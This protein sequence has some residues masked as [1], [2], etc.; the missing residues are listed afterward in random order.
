MT[1]GQYFS[2]VGLQRYTG[3]DSSSV[4]LTH[5]K[6]VIYFSM[7]GDIFKLYELLLILILILLHC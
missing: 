1:E 6:Y 5:E 7:L 4:I 3:F 2:G